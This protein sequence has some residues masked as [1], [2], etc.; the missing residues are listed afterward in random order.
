MSLGNTLDSRKEIKMNS[1]EHKSGSSL[2]IA[3]VV[4]LML[5]TNACEMAK[6]NSEKRHVDFHI[7]AVV[8]AK[9]TGQ[10]IYGADVR[11]NAYKLDDDGDK[12]TD[13]YLYGEKKTKANGECDW[14]FG[15]NLLYD[16]DDGNYLESVEIQ[17]YASKGGL[18]D[19]YIEEIEGSQTETKVLLWLDKDIVETN[20]G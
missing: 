18:Y 3:V 2:W 9:D 19:E 7:T 16:L 15:Y 4:C 14:T 1:K 20:G 12:I 10:P 8:N 13:K 11:F 6:V 5:E 17:V